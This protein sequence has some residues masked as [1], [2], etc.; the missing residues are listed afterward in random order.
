MGFNEEAAAGKQQAKEGSCRPERRS[1]PRRVH[2]HRRDCHHACCICLEVVAGVIRR[3]G[4]E[5]S[6]VASTASVDPASSDKGH[7]PS[8]QMYPV[9]YR[10][11]GFII[12]SQDLRATALCF[13]HSTA[14]RGM[15]LCETSQI[16]NS[17][18]RAQ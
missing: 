4:R 9:L 11:E 2:F 8:S 14:L 5:H 6:R 17:G 16:M 10:G 7:E 1:A 3:N 13:G 15:S 18:A 12:R